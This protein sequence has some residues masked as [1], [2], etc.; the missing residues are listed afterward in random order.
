MARTRKTWRHQGSLLGRSGVL[1]GAEERKKATL[2]TALTGANNDLKFTAQKSGTGGNS[3]RIA[4]INPGGTVA[5]SLSVSGNDITVNLA[6]S[7]GVIAASE[8]ATSIRNSI[9]QH[10]TAGQMVEAELAASNDGTGVVTAMALTNL[11]G[12]TGPTTFT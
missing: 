6:V 10:A 5:R 2:T 11:T 1:S 3:I 12:G 8:T 9:N 7:A 4:Y